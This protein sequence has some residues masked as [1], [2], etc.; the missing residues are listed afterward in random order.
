MKVKK[1]R[2]GIV[3]QL[4]LPLHKP[5]DEERKEANYRAADQWIRWKYPMTDEERSWL[6]PGV[7]LARFVSFL[8][9]EACALA[10]ED[11]TVGWR[12]PSTICL[13]DLKRVQGHEG[14]EP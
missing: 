7:R 12:F 9:C 5:S 10:C 11:H 4:E 6:P 1:I 3:A 2:G 14:R 8:E 13:R